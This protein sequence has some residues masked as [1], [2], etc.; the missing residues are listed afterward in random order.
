M[1]DCQSRLH[2]LPTTLEEDELLLA[3]ITITRLS[4]CTFAAV[5]YRAEKKRLLHAAVEVLEGYLRSAR[6]SGTRQEELQK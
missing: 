5:Q 3:N 4:A 1:E 6:F 2:D